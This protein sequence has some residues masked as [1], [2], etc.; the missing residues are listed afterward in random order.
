M[1]MS[2]RTKVEINEKLEAIA[3]EVNSSYCDNSYIEQKKEDID[4]LIK[5]YISYLK[6]EK[7]E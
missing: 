5:N 3:N 4:Y 6:E 2:E 7:G 1:K